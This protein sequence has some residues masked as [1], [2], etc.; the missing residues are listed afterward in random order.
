MDDKVYRTQVRLRRD[1]PREAAIIEK[2][3]RR[4][5]ALHRNVND[6]I[7]HALDAYENEQ[8]AEERLRKVLREELGTGKTPSEP[9]GP[10][11]DQKE[12]EAAEPEKEFSG[13][14]EDV[15]AFFEKG[16]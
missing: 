1:D 11:A 10:A 9:A 3:N 4:N 2:I 14:D 12:P 8:R 15:K 5:T 6:Y 13:L 7:I 16:L